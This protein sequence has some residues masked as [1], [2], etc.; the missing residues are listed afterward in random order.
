M[1]TATG[2][3]AADVLADFVVG[4]DHRALPS[5]VRAQARRCLADSLATMSAG[6]WFGPDW[7]G[8]DPA[9]RPGR[10]GRPLD[11]V[12]TG[13]G[14]DAFRLAT[15][16]QVLDYSDGWRFGG[17][18]PSSP[19]VAI[20]VALA[21]RARRRGRDL[22]FDS[23]LTALVCGYEVAARIAA[24]GHPEQTLAGLHPTGTTGAP[25]AAAAAAALLGLDRDTTAA[26]LTLAVTYAPLSLIGGIL[27]GATSK[28][29]DAGYAARVGWEA[30][31]L[32]SSGL[33]GWDD[34]VDGPRGFVAATTRG[35]RT[36]VDLSDLGDRFTVEEVYLKPYPACRHTH[37]AIEAGLGL[38]ADG[39]RADRITSVDVATYDVARRVVGATTTASSTYVAAQLSLP[40]ALSL[41]VHD[42]AHGPAQLARRSLDRPSVHALAHR[43]RIRTDPALDAAYPATNPAHVEVLLDDGRRVARRVDIPLGDPRR[44]LDDDAVLAKLPAAH[45]RHAGPISAL[46]DPSTPRTTLPLARLGADLLGHGRPRVSGDGS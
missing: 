7:R 43:V 28:P 5:S 11:A 3:T 17:N 45:A 8:A 25:A 13:T 1:G 19:V 38:Y 15:L 44:P 40:C 18:H 16:A 27:G 29:L 26:A 39:V 32:A 21:M 37:P 33:T 14:A 30:A 42:G 23:V 6:A 31:R 2:L 41:A 20:C 24:A 12:G 9:S 46:L 22:P 4:L 34:A 10:P 36:T 35:A